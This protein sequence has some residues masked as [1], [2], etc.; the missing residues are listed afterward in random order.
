[1]AEKDRVLQSLRVWV[2]TAWADGHIADPERLAL[3]RLIDYAAI[4]PEDRALAHSWLD[5]PI[6]LDVGDLH[7]LS[8]VRKLFIYRVAAA[9]TRVDQHVDPAEQRLLA[10]LR[11]ALDVPE[12]D[13]TDIDLLIDE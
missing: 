5:A 13:V 7:Q 11:A 12:N 4:P 9:L 8:A 3:R 2:A 10:K 1:M 6:E